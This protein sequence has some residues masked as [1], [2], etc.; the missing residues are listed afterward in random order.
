MSFA[1]SLLALVIASAAVA[2]P[3]EYHDLVAARNP[4]LWYRFDEPA[5]A[6]AVINYGSLGHAFDG[7]YL[8]GA[9]SGAPTF[10]GDTGVS[11]NHTAQQYVESNSAVPASL[12]GNP[13]F[14]AEAVVFIPTPNVAQNNYAPFLHW[15]AAATGRSVYFSLWFT[16]TNRAYAGFYNGGLRMS[17][18][19][20]HN[21]W[22]HFVWVRD[23]DDGANGQW[24]GTTLYV[25]G[26][27]V[28]LEPDTVLPGA[29]VI[30]ITS[31]TFR[32]QRAT[33]L[34]RYFSGV[35]D[36]VILYD[37]LLTA[38]EV[39]EHF[40]ALAFL[41]IEV[42]PAD[43][44]NDCFLS[45]QDF[46]D[47]VLAFEAGEESADFDRDGFITGLDFDAFVVAFEAGC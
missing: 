8:N 38:E 26:E 45:G 36:E 2:A 6:T 16:Q 33:N 41:N 43:Y 5:A 18:N 24:E 17:C 32:V 31:T 3:P 42:C 21:A 46:D 13:S 39:R 22:N 28:Q 40:E 27:P 19:F 15:G 34:V 35:V 25:N 23:A 9:A 37:R 44:N 29:P 11:F 1:P 10:V 47:F 30:D 12:T 20:S 4:L 14:T 7:L